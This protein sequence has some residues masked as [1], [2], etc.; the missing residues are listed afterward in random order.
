LDAL[1]PIDRNHFVSIFLSVEM[2]S[3]KFGHDL[4]RE[5]QLPPETTHPTDKDQDDPSKET[6]HAVRR[7]GKKWRK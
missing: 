6:G 5:Y 1:T 7:V 3:F 4:G 2:V